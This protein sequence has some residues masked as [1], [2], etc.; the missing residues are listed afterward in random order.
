MRTRSSSFV[1]PGVHYALLLVLM[2]VLWL[3]GG[4]SRADVAGQVVTRAA[5]TVAV[6]ITL[7][8]GERPSFSENRAVLLI[9]I[10]AIALPM[11][12]LIPMPP[13]VWQALPGRDIIARAAQ[14]AGESQPWRPLSMV[15]SATVNAAASLIVPAA[16][17]LCLSGLRATE[18]PWLVRAVLLLITA[19]MLVGLIQFSG[20]RFPQP[21]IN[22]T[23]DVSGT[24]AN[25]NHF[26]VFL[27]LGCLILPVWAFAGR[28]RP[29]WRVPVAGG[30][31]LLLVLT[32]LASGSRAGMV[33]AA[34][35][36][37]LGPLMIRE[38]LRRALQ[39]QPRWVLPMIVA[40]LVG[41]IVIF[42]FLSTSLG[43]AVSVDRLMAE[44]VGRDMR[45]RGLP[46]VIAMVA[47]YF[48][49]GTGLGTFD[50][51]FRLNEPF[52]LLK[53]TY[54]N[55]AHND[56]LGL[57]L[58][59]G[60]P[61]IVVVVLALMWWLWASWTVWMRSS[62]DR[63]ASLGA[64]VATGRLGSS[65]L[66]VLFLASAV[67]YPVR[68]PLMMAIATIA[69]CWLAWGAV[70]ARGSSLPMVARSI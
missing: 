5:A 3:A 31:F 54:F 20:S 47:H 38:D 68:T 56:Y 35:G 57:A 37:V 42:V 44:D 10:C 41:L 23:N 8:F 6:V 13:A 30:L 2:A 46:T 27:A 11:L 34:I 18:R 59:A 50:P 66:L 17:L 1:A 4:A 26:A 9:L 64:V 58:D 36:M 61:G 55:Q 19:S 25:R 65:M 52:E 51:M 28:R 7:L 49:L 16:V 24:F 29:A 22:Y 60:L 63:S 21:L 43:R 70:A 40:S 39:G 67:D 12:Q 32:I 53:L 48:P 62:L 45:S 33:A 69:G 15:P 14:F